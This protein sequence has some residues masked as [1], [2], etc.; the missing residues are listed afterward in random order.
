MKRYHALLQERT[1]LI[2]EGRTIFEAAERDG[3]RALTAEEAAADDRINARL[4]ELNAEIAREEA[5]RERERLMPA[6]PAEAQPSGNGRLAGGLVAGNEYLTQILA[7]Y[8]APAWLARHPEALKPGAVN[9]AGLPFL[10]PSTEGQRP[11]GYDTGAPLGEFLQAVHKARTQGVVD[12]RL[13]QAA[14]QGQ[15]ESV[16]ADGGFLVQQQ[17]FNQVQINMLTGEILQRVKRIPLQENSN[18]L[19]I[20]VVDETSRAT[21]SR[22]GGVTGYW[23]D[24]A[25]TKIASKTAFYRM[26]LELKK[27]AALLYSTDELLQDAAAL[28]AVMT[29]AMSEELRF[30][31][32]DA[33][34]NGGG[35]GKPLGILQSP[36]LV[37]VAAVGGQ[38]AGTVVA[39][40]LSAM[41]GQMIESS[42]A[43]AVWLINSAV[44]PLLDA[45]F[46]PFGTGGGVAPSFVSYGTDGVMRIKG[47]PVIPIEYAAAPGTIG[48]VILADLG[49]YAFIDRNGIKQD[50]SMHVAFLTDE[51]AFRA[52]YRVD[53]QPMWRT[54]ITPFKGSGAKSPFVALSSTRT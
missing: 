16:G 47:R 40:N 39:A 1:D 11:W 43:N 53:G 7:G 13:I 23:L 19:R 12:P 29:T 25:A 22:F 33:I 21:G 35:V 54:S 50:S 30:Q 4:G 36:A 2:S 14:A 10:V 34:I 3:N 31:V 15:Q 20:N 45:L 9:K 42:R 27:V 49:Q 8:A 28:E 51:T 32:E 26:T 38:G 44:E 17:I 37:T 46:I 48:D 18:G 52:V 6:A 24:E 5:R 41:W